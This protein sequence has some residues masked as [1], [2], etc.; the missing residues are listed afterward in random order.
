MLFRSAYIGST[1]STCALNARGAALRRY[2]VLHDLPGASIIAALK[3]GLHPLA[4]YVLAFHVFT[5]PTAYAGV[6]VLFA[7]MPVGLNAYLLAARYRTEQG[8][9]AASVLVST[10]AAIGTTV[11]WLLMLGRA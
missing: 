4:V 6:A 7:A 8:L 11:G 10:L 2:R 5:M 3:L 9:V 1:A